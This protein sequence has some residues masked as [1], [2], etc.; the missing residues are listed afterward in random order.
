[1]GKTGKDKR[2]IY[3]RRAKELGFRARSAFK[4]IQIDEEFDVFKGVSRVVDL[5][6]AP[7][8]WS[9]VVSHKLY[10]ERREREDR[11]GKSSPIK[12]IGTNCVPKKSDSDSEKSK[13]S[14]QL[15]KNGSVTPPHDDHHRIV[16]VDL[17]KMAPIDGVVQLQGD[18]T[19]KATADKIINLFKGKCADLVICDGAPDVT[20]L[21]DI[22]EYVQAQLLLAALNITTHVLAK[23][24]TFIAKIFR[25]KNITLLYSQLKIFF[26]NVVCCKPKSSRNSSIEAFVVCRNYAPPPTYVPVMSS[27]LLDHNYGVKNEMV[28]VNRTVV[29][30][31]ACGDLSGF[32]SDQSYPLDLKNVLCS[33][34]SASSRA[35]NY[36]YRHL[37]PVQAPITAPYIE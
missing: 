5:C 6:A 23:G 19:S 31:V 17:Q 12:D 20:G 18:I 33:G 9:Q 15:N 25:G 10:G 4:L 24:G 1:M 3:Y 35:S 7:G 11:D 22:D 27:P 21:H 29:P 26:R 34:E 37:E 28:G 8:S 13:D 32:D 30:F 16:A 14:T 36:T 2:D